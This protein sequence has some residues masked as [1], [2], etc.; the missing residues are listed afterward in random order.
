LGG[1]PGALAP[2]QFGCES[3]E[4]LNPEAPVRLQPLIDLPQRFRVHRVE[5]PR[6]LRANRGEAALPKNPEVLGHSR[7]RDAEP[8]LDVGANLAGRTLAVGQQ[9]KDVSPNR[10]P[11]DV[12][13]VHSAV[14]S[15]DAYISER[16]SIL[17]PVVSRGGPGWLRQLRG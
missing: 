2:G 1:A 13:R 17:L 12:E 15:E 8:G 9:L 5:A 11:E 7:L 10:I 16:L 3:V 14:I 6:S 4:T